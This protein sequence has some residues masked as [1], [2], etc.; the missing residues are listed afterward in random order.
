M[1]LTS[2]SSGRRSPWIWRPLPPSRAV[3][4]GKSVGRRCVQANRRPRLSAMTVTTFDRCLVIAAA[5]LVA[6]YVALAYGLAPFAWRLYEHQ[7]GLAALGART[8]HGPRHSGRRDQLGLE[9]SEADVDCAMT[10]ARWSPSDPVTFEPN[11]ADPSRS[12][13]ARRKSSLSSSEGAQPLLRPLHLVVRETEFCGLRLAG[14]FRRRMRRQ[15]EFGSQTTLRLTNPPELRG[16]LSTRKPPRFVG[17]GWWS[18][19]DSNRDALG[20][21]F[22]NLRAFPIEN[23]QFRLEFPPPRE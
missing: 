8:L 7:K 9:G 3:L 18:G 11:S 4:A 17:T 16:F 2:L 6:A 23:Q 15:L 21:A 14:D 5:A 20:D 22:V 1:G 10:A 12:F 19:G 13:P